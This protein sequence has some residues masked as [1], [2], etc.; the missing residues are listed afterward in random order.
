MFVRVCERPFSLLVCLCRLRSHI[1]KSLL[2]ISPLGTKVCAVI[3]ERRNL[4][5][6]PL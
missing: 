4:S 3:Y 5:V 2:H 1:W 6:I